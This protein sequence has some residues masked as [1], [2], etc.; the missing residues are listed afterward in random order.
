MSSGPTASY[1]L[2]SSANPKEPISI[3]PPRNFTAVYEKVLPGASVFTVLCTGDR[4]GPVGNVSLALKS[5]SFT[6]VLVS[7]GAA[8]AVTVQAFDDT[9]S[10]DKGPTVT[11]R[12]FLPAGTEARVKFERLK[13]DEVPLTS[14]PVKVV[15][16]FVPVSTVY[17]IEAKLADGK[18]LSSGGEVDL[19]KYPN[20]TILVFL[21][22]EGKV[23]A[24]AAID[25][26][27][28]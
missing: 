10:K 8:Q 26:V 7:P 23:R 14:A 1:D 15:R 19:V 24:R 28:Q 9:P 20:V 16:G 18:L 25:G 13:V 12:N 22:P 27:L 21:N 3:A 2:V 4:T 6:T 5:G 17:T 11:I